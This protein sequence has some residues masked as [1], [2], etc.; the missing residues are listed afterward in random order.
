MADGILVVHFAF[1]SFVVVGFLLILIGLVAGWSWVRNR[2]FRLAHVAAILIVVAQA[3]VGRIC[4]L[5]VWENELR[6]RA[7][8]DAYSESF[9]QHWLHRLLFYDAEPWV[10]T[11]IYTVFGALVVLVWWL[12]GPAGRR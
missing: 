11:T 8:Q 7:G 6:R 2:W 5:T 10:F 9:V 12:S 4:P 1:V 3:W